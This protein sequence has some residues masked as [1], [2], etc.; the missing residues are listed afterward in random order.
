M[1]K[2]QLRYMARFC[3]LAQKP[4]EDREVSCA[5]FRELI[6]LLDGDYPGYAAE[7]YNMIGER[8]ECTLRRAEVAAINP[9]A[10]EPVLDGDC[11]GF[12]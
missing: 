6:K 3:E 4:L 8:H 1:A 7:F 2:I 12:Y 10:D 5:T 11:Y 9:T